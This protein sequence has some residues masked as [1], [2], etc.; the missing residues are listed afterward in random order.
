MYCH[1]AAHHNAYACLRQSR[2]E[3]LAAAAGAGSPGELVLQMAEECLRVLVGVS[4]SCRQA[5]AV[6]GDSNECC[7]LRMRL[8]ELPVAVAQTTARPDPL[9]IRWL[10]CTFLMHSPSYRLCSWWAARV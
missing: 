5:Y 1:V 4:Q 7:L 10:A 8:E 3:Q 6:A 9:L 2:F